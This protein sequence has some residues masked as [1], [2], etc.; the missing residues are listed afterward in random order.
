MRNITAQLLHGLFHPQASGLITPKSARFTIPILNSFK[1]KH[2]QVKWFA[3]GSPHLPSTRPV[4]YPPGNIPSSSLPDTL[5]H[6]FWEENFSMNPAFEQKFS[7]NHSPSTTRSTHTDPKA[8]EELLW[9]Q[10]D[11]T[12]EKDPSWHIKKQNWDKLEIKMLFPHLPL[13]FSLMGRV[14]NKPPNKQT[15]KT[16]KIDKKLPKKSAITTFQVFKPWLLQA[17]TTEKFIWLT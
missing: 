14:K 17:S 6:I 9:N 5:T 11:F 10:R 7:P 16:P 13:S 2:K 12:K 4:L 15:K 1:R 3:S 8:Q